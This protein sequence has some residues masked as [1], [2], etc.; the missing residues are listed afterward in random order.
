MAPPRNSL[1]TRTG[2]HEKPLPERMQ[3]LETYLVELHREKNR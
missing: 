3:S 2:W 1:S